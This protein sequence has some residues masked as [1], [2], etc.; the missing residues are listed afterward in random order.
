M[1]RLSLFAL[2]SAAILLVACHEIDNTGLEA[3]SAPIGQMADAT[4]S[5]NVS[6]SEAIAIADM[7]ECLCFARV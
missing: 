7:K 3:E 4:Q 1:K 6:Q 5:V 2:L